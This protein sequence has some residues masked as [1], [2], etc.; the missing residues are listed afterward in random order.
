MSTVSNQ[1][2][3]SWSQVVGLMFGPMTVLSSVFTTLLIFNLVIAN[4]LL[5]E[6]ITPPKV[7]GAVFILIGALHRRPSRATPPPSPPP[8]PRHP[9]RQAPDSAPERRPR[10]SPRIIAPARSSRCSP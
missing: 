10:A 8:L 7:A 2:D 4:K 1:G 3:A 6:K 9:R 5:D